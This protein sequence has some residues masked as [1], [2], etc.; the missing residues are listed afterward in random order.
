MTWPLRKKVET[1]AAPANQVQPIPLEPI[2]PEGGYPQTVEPVAPPYPQ[3]YQQPGI[4]IQQADL[5]SLS[6]HLVN[7]SRGINSL[8]TE[9]TAA[10]SILQKYGGA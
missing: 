1:T 3:P 8:N 10:L 5:Q 9:L 2:M 4:A 6:M 7:I